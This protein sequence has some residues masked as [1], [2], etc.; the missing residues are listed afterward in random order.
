[1]KSLNLGLLVIRVGIGMIF[2][3]HGLPKIMGGP[4]TW[5]GIGQ[6][7]AVLGLN[8]PIFLT[9][10]LGFMAACSEGIGG[11]LLVLGLGTRI[12]AFFMACTMAVAVMFHLARHDAWTTL[13]HPLSLLVVFIGLMIAGAGAYS[14][15]A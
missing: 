14:L 4:A 6:S 1:M 3:R 2:M 8:L 7:L 9:T 11:A 12:A 5:Q 15:D 10:T 13:S